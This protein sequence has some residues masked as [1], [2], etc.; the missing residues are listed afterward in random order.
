MLLKKNKAVSV[1]SGALVGV[2]VQLIEVE[3]DQRPGVTKMYIVGLPDKACAEAKERIKSAIR[4]S[5]I[6]LPGCQVVLNLAPADLPK[7]GSGFDLAMAVALLLRREELPSDSVNG[8]VLLGELALDGKLRPVPG[9]LAAAEKAKSQGFKHLIVPAD[10]Q[11]EA[12]LV[13]G[14]NV[15]PAISLDE[16][17]KH[18]LGSKQLP[19]SPLTPL[20]QSAPSVKS[21]SSVIDF[22]HVRGHAFAKRAL[23]IAAAGGH[24]VLLSGP[25]GSGKT[26]LA[27]AMLSIMPPMRIEEVV[28]V[29][30]IHSAAGQ[31]S[32]QV[33]YIAQRP[34]RN[35]HHSA[36][37]VALVGGGSIPKPGEISLAHRGVLFF[38]NNI[39]FF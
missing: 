1:I 38:F 8:Y 27:K 10:N 4:N 13:D 37:A 35:P 11:K 7:S 20:F 26:M 15:Y 18:F 28:E 6:R 16:V 14:I 22:Q 9:V 34:W 32:S 30:K 19:I 36:S 2:D 12:A 24:N 21:V 17:I 25:P 3:A 5:G 29:T 31:L 23:E 33:P 39:L